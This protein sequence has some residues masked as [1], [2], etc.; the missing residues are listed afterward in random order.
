MKRK[1][2]ILLSAMLLMQAVCG[3]GGTTSSGTSSSSA[4][5]L[6]VRKM[7]SRIPSSI[8]LRKRLYTVCQEP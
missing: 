2:A 7:L 8:H 3:C 1:F 5:K 6:R 4:S